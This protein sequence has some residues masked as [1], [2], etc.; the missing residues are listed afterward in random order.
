MI[1]PINILLV[2]D[3]RANRMVVRAYFSKMPYTLYDAVNGAIA[4]EMFKAGNYD[5]VL[6]DIE[7]PMMDGYT[8]TRAIRAIENATGRRHVPILALTASVVAEALSKALDAGCDAHIAKPV[9]K[10]T[11]LA[12]ID[13]AISAVGSVGLP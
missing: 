5:L 3:S 9:N 1:K 12:A 6:M 8:A 13:K 10:A 7:M 4:V 11:L 2:D